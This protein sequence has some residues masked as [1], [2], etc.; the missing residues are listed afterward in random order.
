MAGVIEWLR[1]GRE[2]PA[3]ELAGRKVPIELTRH[4]RARR[5]TMRLAPD[6]GAVR[7]TL[8]RWCRSEDAL[9]FAFARQNWLEGQ[10]AKLPAP[11]D[12][13]ARGTMRYRGSEI[14]IEWSR[15][16]PRR[17]TLV[18]G[19]LTVGGPRE[20]LYPRLQ[21]WLEAEAQR[22]IAEDLAHYCTA[23]S[24]AQPQL[25]LTRAGRRWGSCSTKGV[26]RVNWRLAMAPDF[27]RRSVVAH[28]V[29][30][31]VHFDHSPAFYGLL[32]RLYE[33]DVATADTWLRE[34]GRSLYADFG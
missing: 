19:Q 3:I 2:P 29:A 33:G 20:T 34:H 10:A 4:P 18:S 32:A 12:P 13:V 25:K 22:L 7:I 8:P 30:H 28:E 17:A 23:A 16:A 14:T 27:V 9:S 11:G 1:A 31:L 21:R 26:V 6:G 15:E 24:V 5:L